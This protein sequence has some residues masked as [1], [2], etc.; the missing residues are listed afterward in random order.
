MFLEKLLDFAFVGQLQAMAV[1]SLI[2]SVQVFDLVLV[3]DEVHHPSN[4]V[5]ANSL[6][7]EEPCEQQQVHEIASIL[8]HPGSRASRQPRR[9]R[10]EHSRP[11][12]PLLLLFLLRADPSHRQLASSPRHGLEAN[13]TRTNT[14]APITSPTRCTHELREHGRRRGEWVAVLLLAAGCWLLLRCVRREKIRAGDW[15]Q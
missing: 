4:F 15:P 8:Q 13:K 9:R 5:D 14:R 1:K 10:G 11:S 3:M 12:L 6:W 7:I 2:L